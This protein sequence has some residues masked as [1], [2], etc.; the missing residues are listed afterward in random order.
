MSRPVMLETATVLSGTAHRSVSALDVVLLVVV[1]IGVA[2]VWS[3]GEALVVMLRVRA[4][5]AER[6]GWT[7]KRD[8]SAMRSGWPRLTEGHVGRARWR[9]LMSG[10]VPGAVS[11]DVFR[12]D[13]SKPTGKNSNT[14]VH[15]TTAIVV[16]PFPLPRVSLAYDA[17]AVHPE[18][19]AW[20]KLRA[21]VDDPE[22][23]AALFTMDVLDAARAER[24]RWE[25]AGDAVVFTARR[26]LAP[27]RM[28]QL[29]DHAV[30]LVQRLPAPVLDRARAGAVAAGEAFPMDRAAPRDHR[31]PHQA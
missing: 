26:S 27:A 25:M 18:Q 5:L 19:L 24:Y 30:A 9:W 14:S 15:T 4:A 16:F 28:L 10:Q 8:A 23:A 7:W 22:A 21:E 29:V 11:A 31:R 20:D 13:S 1:V 12:I 6:P 3:G 2:L 17:K